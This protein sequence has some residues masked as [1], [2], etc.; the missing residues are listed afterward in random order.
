[1][2]EHNALAGAGLRRIDHVGI[3]VQSLDESLKTY[4]EQLGFTLLQRIAIP[5]Q[6]VEAAFL[7]A[8][9]GTIELISPTDTTSGT[10]RF[11]QNRGE[12]THHVCFEV[13]DIVAALEALRGQGVRLIDE[14]PRRGVHGLVAFVHPKATHGTMIELLQKDAH[15]SAPPGPAPGMERRGHG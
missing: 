10:A 7:D 13:E 3:V 5:E 11:L 12:G 8:G 6:M 9:N 15:H 14:T 2:S 1:M 4:C